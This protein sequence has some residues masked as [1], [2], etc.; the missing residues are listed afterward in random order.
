MRTDRQDYF[1]EQGRYFVQ[2]FTNSG[3][4]HD[5]AKKVTNCLHENRT[6]T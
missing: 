5:Y 4:P 1:V 2:S 3:S 6:E